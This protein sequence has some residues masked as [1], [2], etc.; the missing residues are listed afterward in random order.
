MATHNSQRILE[1]CILQE[2]KPRSVDTGHKR[3]KSQKAFRGELNKMKL[4]EIRKEKIKNELNKLTGLD[5]KQKVDE[6]LE[7][8]ANDEGKS[9]DRKKAKA[10][11]TEEASGDC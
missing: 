3:E 10:K 7:S 9:P 2:A 11:V 5:S 1:Q 8:V 4:Q 6:L